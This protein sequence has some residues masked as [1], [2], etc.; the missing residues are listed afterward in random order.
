MTTANETSEQLSAV[1]TSVHRSDAHTLRKFPQE[2]I[3]LLSGLGVEGDAHMGTTVKHRSRV[4]R[5][6][7]EPNLRQVH[8][9]QSELHDELRERGFTVDFGAMGENITTRGVDLLGLPRGARLH[10]GPTAIIEITGLRSPCG[11]LDTIQPGLKDAVLDRDEAGEVVRKCGVMAVVVDGGVLRA[12]DVIQ[13]EL[14]TG[15]QR[16]LS[17]V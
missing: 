1:V 3:N 12:G 2:S 9:I 7:D 13:V 15:E 4:A 8:L 17:V 14:P 5:T 6:P 11:Q 10:M 16:A